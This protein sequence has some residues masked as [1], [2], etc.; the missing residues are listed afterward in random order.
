MTVIQTARLFAG[1]PHMPVTRTQTRWVWSRVSDRALVVLVPFEAALEIG[2]DMSACSASYHWYVRP[3][4]LAKTS[5]VMVQPGAVA[6]ELFGSR[7]IAG[8]VQT[9]IVAVLLSA[10]RPQELVAR[11]Q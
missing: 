6:P 1:V 9:V 2:A 3:A 7:V 5:T 4:P 11:T 10:V 8:P